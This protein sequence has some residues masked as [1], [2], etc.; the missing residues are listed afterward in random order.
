MYD[1]Y[2]DRLTIH[3]GGLRGGTADG[4][5]DHR[6]VMSAA[7][8]GMFCRE[9]V[10]IRGAEAVHKSYPDFFEDFKKLGGLC[11]VI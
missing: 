8:A 10:L 9:P 11:D 6:V 3:G 5:N 2:P 4:A 1:E 7:I